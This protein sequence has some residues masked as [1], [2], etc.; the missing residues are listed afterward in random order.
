MSS[1]Q[2]CILI[3]TLAVSIC[4]GS[5]S[6]VC[7]TTRVSPEPCLPFPGGEEKAAV[8]VEKLEGRIELSSASLYPPLLCLWRA[9]GSWCIK[10]FIQFQV[11]VRSVWQG[12]RVRGVGAS[13]KEVPR[14]E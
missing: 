3:V 9:L 2:S 11:M 4:G 12:P 1:V 8:I 13:W 6:T 14:R 10:V 5:L 7:S